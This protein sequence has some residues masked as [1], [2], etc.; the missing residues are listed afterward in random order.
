MV[1][2]IDTDCKFRVV[3]CFFP[4]CFMLGLFPMSGLRMDHNDSSSNASVELLPRAIDLCMQ[5][6][7]V[8]SQLCARINGHLLVD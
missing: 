7:A 1:M 8:G 2:L 3:N 4:V 6:Q 5:Q